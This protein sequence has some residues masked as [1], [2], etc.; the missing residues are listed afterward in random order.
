MSVITRRPGTDYLQY[1]GYDAAGRRRRLSLRTK[2]TR[3]AKFRKAEWD[4][5]LLGSAPRSDAGITT[6]H[7]VLDGYLDSIAARRSDINVRINRIRAGVIKSN[8]PDRA[9]TVVQ[10]GDVEDLLNLL[11]DTRG[12]GDRSR[13][14]YL[15]LIRAASRWSVF[16]RM[17]FE[18]FTQGVSM[19]KL[20]ERPV[21]A[22]TADQRDR[23]LDLSAGHPQY[24]MYATAV[25]A[26]LRWQ[27]LAHSERPEVDLAARLITIQPKEGWTPKSKRM[28]KVPICSRLL[29]ILTDHLPEHGYC[30][31]IQRGSHSRGQP[32]RTRS[33]YG[34]RHFLKEVGAYTKGDGWHL[35]R[36]TFF[37][38]LLQN[39]VDPLKA[40]GWIGHAAGGLPEP[41]RRYYSITQTYDPDIERQ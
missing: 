12:I 1:D 11:M 23:L 4:K 37:T 31:T 32:Y 35:L 33:R 15:A 17:T 18:D 25:F 7:Q 27:E 6:F 28:R 14:E 29:A 2:D 19:V 16:R 3:L 38:R 39:G 24:P 41:S 34:I 5:K 20:G 8:F 9:V 36:R 30:F 26:G 40:M 22:L 10:P 13:N 21:T